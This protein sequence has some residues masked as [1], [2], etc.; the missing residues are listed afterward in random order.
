MPLRSA[1]LGPLPARLDPLP[2][3]GRV[4]IFERAIRIGA[5]PAEVRIRRRGGYPPFVQ[6]TSAVAAYLL[7]QLM[8]I[9]G[10][11]TRMVLVVTT[12]PSFQKNP[13]LG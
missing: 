3:G 9:D 10:W 4:G 6:F 5:A 7:G 1:R 8:R 11:S 13:P 2:R 12:L